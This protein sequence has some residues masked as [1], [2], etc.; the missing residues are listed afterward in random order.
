MDTGTSEHAATRSVLETET[1]LRD[2]Y[3]HPSELA[4]RKQLA[5]LDKHAKRFIE[6]SP[7]LVISTQGA[8]GLGDVSPKGDAPGFVAVLDDRTI[9]IPDRPGNNRIDTLG[10]L[11][12]N[13][14]VGILFLIPGVN[15]TLRINGR[16]RVIADTEMLARFAVRDRLPKTGI[17]VEVEEMYLHC[18]KALVRSKLWTEDY[19]V[20][21]KVLPSLGQMIADQVEGAEIDVAEAD[22]RIADSEKNRLY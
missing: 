8:D 19:K 12:E 14:G 9:L 2:I 11:T 15:E 16:A 7:F 17:L 5:H 4:A 13:P 18:A 21:R 6:L 22:R 3:G 10:N 1:A 20:E